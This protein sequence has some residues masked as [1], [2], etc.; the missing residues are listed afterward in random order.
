MAGLK[1]EADS[2]LPSVLTA[3]AIVSYFNR[4]QCLIFFD[5]VMLSIKFA[6]HHPSERDDKRRRQR[7]HKSTGL[8]L[9]KK[10]KKNRGSQYRNVKPGV[11]EKTEKSTTE[12]G[13][14][15][16]QRRGPF[17]Q[18]GGSFTYEREKKEQ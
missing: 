14:D 6:G 16:K 12:P 13:G 8:N 2:F 5:V 11:K 18:K 15:G 7:R 10:E 4:G 9:S 1:T 3:T 17:I